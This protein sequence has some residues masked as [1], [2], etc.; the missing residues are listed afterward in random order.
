MAQKLRRAR[1]PPNYKLI[2]LDVVSLFTKIPKELVYEAVHKKWSKIQKFTSLP[3]AE[4]LAGLKLVMEE[5][6]FQFNGAFY[7]QIFGS[8]MGSPS[9]P[10][11]ADLILEILQEE[12]IRK[13]GFNLPFF[14]RYVDDILTA[15]PVDKVNHIKSFFNSY[16]AH[17]Q[18]TVE[19]EHENQISF[20]EL[21]CIRENRSIKTDWYHKDTWS[22]RYLNFESHLPMTYKR[23]TVALL[24]EKILLLSEFQQKNFELLRTTLKNNLYPR[25]LV[26]DIIQ[27]TTEK[28]NKKRRSKDPE[29]RKPIIAVP[30]V[31]GLFEKLKSTCK[32]EFT[33][34][35]K[36]DNSLRKMVFSRLKNKTPKMQQSNVVY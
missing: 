17:I 36:A 26:N 6:F 34:V 4:F 33:V 3:K 23:N 25:K 31:K 22:G 16:N 10:V 27:Q 20:L 1:L 19:E 35:G 7:K 8:P 28:I 32:N 21:M 12:V 5:C 15:V 29:E 9:S 14:I 24:T 2:S 30:Y 13:L 11:F 18:F